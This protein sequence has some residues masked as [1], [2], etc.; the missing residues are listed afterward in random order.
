M[1][2]DSE[3]L[4]AEEARIS[5]RMGPSQFLR[6]LNN[7]VIETDREVE[8][9]A[10]RSSRRV[11]TAGY[12]SGPPPAL[13]SLADLPLLKVNVFS[14]ERHKARQPPSPASILGNQANSTAAQA[15]IVPIIDQAP[16]LPPGHERFLDSPTQK[17]LLNVAEDLI[18]SGNLG[19]KERKYILAFKYHKT[20]NLSW[21]RAYQQ[22]PG[23]GRLSK[24]KETQERNFYLWAEKG[25]K[26][27]REHASQ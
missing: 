21:D 3:W 18:K 16:V 15:A 24:N 10:A 22:I 26:L 20:S 5:L 2:N 12:C 13:F 11:G 6:L 27:C 4:P 25:E 19:D 9:V 7:G 14:L 17:Q 8:R 23:T 1:G